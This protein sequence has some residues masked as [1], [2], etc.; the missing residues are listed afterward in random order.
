[1][2]CTILA[3]LLAIHLFLP[4]SSY[5][6]PEVTVTNLSIAIQ[7]PQTPTAVKEAVS[8]ISKPVSGTDVCT[9]PSVSIGPSQSLDLDSDPRLRIFEEL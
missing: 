2:V 9:S 3:A 4:T 1:M 5:E 8:H 7:A 6:W